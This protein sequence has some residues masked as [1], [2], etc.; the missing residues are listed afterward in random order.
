M[1]IVSET[2]ATSY[3]PHVTEKFFFSIVTHGLF[4]AYAQPGWHAHLEKYAGFKKYTKLFDYRFDSIQNP[5]ERLVELITMV[6]KFSHLSRFDWHD[7]YL[8]E[9]DTIDYNYDHYFSEKFVE[10]I[11]TN[12]RAQ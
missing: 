5:V 4:L 11:K 8:M 12:I 10:C 2:M 3:Q 6:S 1:H 7:L 9:K